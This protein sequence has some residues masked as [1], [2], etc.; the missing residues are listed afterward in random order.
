MALFGSRPKE[1]RTATMSAER[2]GSATIITHGS[3]IRGDLIGKDT[4]QID[5]EVEGN[6][7]VHNI[8]MIGKS[9]SVKG[10]IKATKVI[11][12]GHVLGK[13]DCDELEVL[14]SSVVK[15]YVHARKVVV[16][17]KI[18]GEVRCDGMIVEPK[19][20]VGLK[21]Q[22]KSI[23]IGGTVSGE[24]AAD[25]MATKA[26][27][28]VKATMYV[29]NISNEGG[30]VEGSIGAFKEILEPAADS[31]TPPSDAKAALKSEKKG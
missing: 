21:I 23:V 1:E 18:E 2:V 31:K 14:E 19:G 25:M 8:V 16:R 27:G 20:Y 5:G 26:T 9:G 22:A 11:S 4:V 6:V 15:E 7:I 10:T 12:S 13:V 30:R 29:N 24:V 17:G 28:Y 3:K